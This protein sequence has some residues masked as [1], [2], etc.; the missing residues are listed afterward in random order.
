MKS[1]ADEERLG[2]AL[3]PGLD[4][5]LDAHPE[6]RAVA[7]EPLELGRVLGVVM[8][9]TSRMPASMSVDSG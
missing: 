3:G 8:T 2:E 9:S 7:E 4:G 5:V 1:L 6:G